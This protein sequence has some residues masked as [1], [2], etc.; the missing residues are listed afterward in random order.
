MIMKP[1]RTQ[2]AMTDTHYVRMRRYLSGTVAVPRWPDDAYL[3]TFSELQAAAAHALL[4]LTYAHGGGSVASFEEW[5]QGLSGDEEY[6]RSLCFPVYDA[7]DRIIGFCQCW[8]TAFVK[9]LVVH[10]EYQRR[11]VGS[12]LL[13]HAFQVFA[14]RGAKTVDLKVRDNNFAALRFY[15]SLRMYRLPI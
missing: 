5:W 12:A 8:T 1:E 4:Q 11:G 15:E 2:E 7:D 14:D 13:L 6:D 9:D 10:P 3:R